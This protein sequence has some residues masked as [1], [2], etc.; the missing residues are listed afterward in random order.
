MWPRLQLRLCTETDRGKPVQPDVLVP[1]TGWGPKSKVLTGVGAATCL[2]PSWQALPGKAPPLP[3][4]QRGGW[5]VS[6]APHLLTLL[7]SPKDQPGDR[8]QGCR[9]R[10]SGT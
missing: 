7:N 9:P 6:D 4:P 10:D 2:L 8:G 1:S 5:R 3:G